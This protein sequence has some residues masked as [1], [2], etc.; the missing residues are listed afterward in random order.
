LLT[1]LTLGGHC[2]AAFKFY[3]SCLRGK[4]DPMITFGS[5]P[6]ENPLPAACRVA[7]KNHARA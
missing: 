1:Y 6:S 7:R 2:E 5:A 4:I 3:E